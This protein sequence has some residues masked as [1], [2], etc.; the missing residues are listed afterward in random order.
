MGVLGYRDPQERKCGEKQAPPHQISLIAHKGDL[1]AGMNIYIWNTL[2]K[3]ELFF[4]R[5][6]IQGKNLVYGTKYFSD[7]PHIHSAI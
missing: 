4:P 3:N 5:T 2:Y 6:R 1:G 7:P